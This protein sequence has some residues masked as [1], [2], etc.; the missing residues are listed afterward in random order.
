MELV[1]VQHILPS[2][3]IHQSFPLQTFAL[4]SN[5]EYSGNTVMFTNISIHITTIPTPNTYLLVMQ[6]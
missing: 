2:I 6:V 3:P 1:L 4:Y 5:N